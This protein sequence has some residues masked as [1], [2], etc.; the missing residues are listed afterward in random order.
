MAALAPGN[1]TPE[2]HEVMEEVMARG[3]VFVMGT[4]AGA[5]RLVPLE[6]RRPKG[7]VLADNLTVQKAR[8]LLMLGLARTRDLD[9]LQALF[10]RF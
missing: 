7:T 10:Y 2:E 5:G 4:R 3:V 9:E 8:V 6:R 1:P